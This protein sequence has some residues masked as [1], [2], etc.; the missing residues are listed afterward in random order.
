MS[1][2]PDSAK[3]SN[4]KGLGILFNKKLINRLENTVGQGFRNHSLEYNFSSLFDL[5]FIIDLN[6]YW[7]KDIFYELIKLVIWFNAEA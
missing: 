4:S 7:K 3:G 6:Y 5:S 1:P 2:E